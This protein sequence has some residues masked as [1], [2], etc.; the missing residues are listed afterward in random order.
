MRAALV[1][2]ALIQPSEGVSCA[3]R[4]LQYELLP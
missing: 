1:V 2:L 4:G 3:E